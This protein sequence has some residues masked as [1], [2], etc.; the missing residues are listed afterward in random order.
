MI[1]DIKEIIDKYGVMQ[2][3]GSDGSCA[4]GS[5]EIFGL[6]I[7]THCHKSNGHYYSAGNRCGCHYSC[8]HIEKYHDISINEK[9]LK[10]I[11]KIFADYISEAYLTDVKIIVE[12]S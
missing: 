5:C 2:L 11:G 10:E 4:C 9:E 7:D 12:K 6:K 8:V 3:L 1:K